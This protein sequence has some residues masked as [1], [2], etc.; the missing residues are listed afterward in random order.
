MRILRE[1]DFGLRAEVWTR[2]TL[3]FVLG[4]VTWYLS[5]AAL[6]GLWLSA[7]AVTE[8]F[9][10][11]SVR[12]RPPGRRLTVWHDRW[13]FCTYIISA[14]CF[15]SLPLYLTHS[16]TP[17][18]SG[19]AL[20]GQLGMIVFML[21]RIQLL[22]SINAFH[23]FLVVLFA[24]NTSLA[25]RNLMETPT[26]QALF[27]AI[28]FSI[29]GYCVFG[30]VRAKM[31]FLEQQRISERSRESERVE[32]VARLTGGVAHD[33]NNLLTV[34]LGNLELYWH[35]P[36]GEERDTLIREATDAAQRGAHLTSQ[37]LAYS[38]K[39]P[40]SPQTAPL[41]VHVE[42]A[43][44]LIGRLLPKRIPLTIDI[45]RNAGT[46][47]VDPAQFTAALLNLVSNAADAIGTGTGGV[48]ISGWPLMGPKG[49]KSVILSVSDRGGGM[50]EGLE[51]RV[52]E[53]FFTTKPVGKGSGLG[54]S[55]VKGFAEQ[56]GGRLELQNRPG[57][58]VT[59]TLVLPFAEPEQG[60]KV[61]TPDAT[62][63][64]ITL[65]G[66]RTTD[67]RDVRT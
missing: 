5:G 9:Y 64:P 26:H 29:A 14:L 46:V 19:A 61:N 58:G 12:E 38:R 15:V 30:L 2:Y 49:R 59:V 67:T 7:Y 13:A 50:P 16:D 18:L 33:F 4:G 8:I 34:V 20:L 36:P 27:T 55:M 17:L 66:A 52:L 31:M 48:T 44:P 21:W 24:T 1:A 47:A 23:C 63:S 65:S 51:E 42:A 37:L 28:L 25:Y 62:A 32:T 45:A 39:A 57:E 41:R 11:L 60:E 35:C 22:N 56:S 3:I 6:L 53:P 43:M 54:L 40:M 10:Y